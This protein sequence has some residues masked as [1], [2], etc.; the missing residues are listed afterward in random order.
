MHLSAMMMPLL[1]AML[2]FLPE[3]EAKEIRI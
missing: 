1:Q 2:Q 3:K